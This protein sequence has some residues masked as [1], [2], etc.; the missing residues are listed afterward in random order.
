MGE[1]YI[2]QIAAALPKRLGKFPFWRSETNLTERLEMIYRTSS[3][4]GLKILL[5]ER[6]REEEDRNQGGAS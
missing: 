5:G 2:P 3:P 4:T 1:V 6:D